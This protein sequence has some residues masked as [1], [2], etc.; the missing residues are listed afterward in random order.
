M[1]LFAGLSIGEMIG[2]F[3][4]LW[5]M[6]GPVQDVL[7]IQ[8]SYFSAKAALGRINELMYLPNEPVYQR[9]Q[10]PFLKQKGRNISRR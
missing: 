6:M 7:N 10:N 3:G 2:V 4:Y 5:F 9:E 1:V 8:Y